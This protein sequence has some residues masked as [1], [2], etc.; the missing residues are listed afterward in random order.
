MQLIIS[1]DILLQAIN[2]IF[3]A[4]DKRH[5]MII[6]ANMKLVLTETLLL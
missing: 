1:R 5:T 3:K 6:L 2:L 4:A